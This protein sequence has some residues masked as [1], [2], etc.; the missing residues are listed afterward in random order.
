MCSWVLT[1][2]TWKTFCADV[3]IRYF[4]ILLNATPSPPGETP[5]PWLPIRIEDT[6]TPYLNGTEDVVAAVPDIP[7][8]GNQTHTTRAYEYFP[9]PTPKKT[10][11][12]GEVLISARRPWEGLEDDGKSPATWI[13]QILRPI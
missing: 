8:T 7:E 3:D 12:R 1:A 2:S 6:S 5:R 13:F 11:D 9:P 4:Q 10:N